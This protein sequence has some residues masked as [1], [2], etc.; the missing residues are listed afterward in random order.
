[1]SR[2]LVVVLGHMLILVLGLSFSCGCRDKR[3]TLLTFID[4][5]L[6]TDPRESTIM[7]LR[8]YGCDVRRLQTD[9]KKYFTTNNLEDLTRERN[10][11]LML[12]SH[13]ETLHIR[14]L[15]KSYRSWARK[16]FDFFFQSVNVV[17]NRN[18]DDFPRSSYVLLFLHETVTGTWYTIGI[19]PHDRNALSTIG[20]VGARYLLYC[21]DW[22]CRNFIGNI[23]F[24]QG[25]FDEERFDAAFVLCMNSLNAAILYSSQE[26]IAALRLRSGYPRLRLCWRTP[27]CLIFVPQD[28][29]IIEQSLT[30]KWRCVK[31]D[32]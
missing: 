32:S 23:S 21:R 24:S 19:D 31:T 29:G 2:K 15:R 30:E 12:K 5:N 28:F 26:E 22:I 14:E 18:K 4:D 25:L 11:L 20:S 1:M 7:G 17:E 8:T 13:E 3:Q 9:M 10:C 16:D 27:N 6:Y